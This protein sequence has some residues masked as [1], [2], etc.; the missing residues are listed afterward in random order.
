MI[1][2]IELPDGKL[3]ILNDDGVWQCEVYTM[4]RLLNAAYS[5]LRSEMSRAMPDWGRLEL[6]KAARAMGKK[7]V[8]EEKQYDPDLVF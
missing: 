6:M 8:F 2:Y 4:L 7:P 3:A 5:P 1:G